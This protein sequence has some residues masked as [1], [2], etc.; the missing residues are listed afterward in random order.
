MDKAVSRCRRVSLLLAG[1]LLA[2]CGG[3][4]TDRAAPGASTDLASSSTAPIHRWV[5][6]EPGAGPLPTQLQHHCDTART[7]GLRPYAELNATW[8]APCKALRRAMDDPAMQEAFAGT[9]IIGVD[10]DAFARDLEPLGL[11]TPGVPAIF[12][13]GPDCRATGARIT[14]GAWGADEPAEMAPPLRAFFQGR[15]DEAASSQE[16]PSPAP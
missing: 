15:P 14:G 12:A 4:S 7:L 11:V 13:L 8:C 3:T 2:A 10:V 5:D 6:A 1:G 9:Y 16:T